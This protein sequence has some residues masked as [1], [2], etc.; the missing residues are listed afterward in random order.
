MAKPFVYIA[1][2][3]TK[4]DPA[5]NTRFQCEVF[6]ELLSSGLVLPYAPLMSHFQHTIFPRPYQDW[7]QYDLD[8]LPRFDAAIRLTA[9]Y[10]S[11]K[12]GLVYEQHA[13][14][15]ADGEVAEM[16]RLGKPVF[17]SITD[18]YKWAREFHATTA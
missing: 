15:G 2:A 17:Y 5:I 13:S 10:T 14:S 4:G 16:E 7:V 3:Y 11:S 8:I 9:I 12:T 18:I 1:S 6:D